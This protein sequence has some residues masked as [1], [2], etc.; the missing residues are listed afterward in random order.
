[1]QQTNMV[2]GLQRIGVFICHCG[3]NIAGTVDMERVTDEISRHPGVVHAENYIYMCSEPGQELMRKAIAEKSLN[4]IVNA[5]CSPS[6]HEKTFRRLAESQGL[7]PYCCEIA[8]IREQCSW[9]HIN[10]KEAA[11]EKAI[12]ITRAAVEK[13]R[14][15][16]TLLPIVVPLTRRALVIG[17][18][19]AGIQVALDIAGSGYPVVLVE[20][21]ESIGGHVNQLSGTFPTMEKPT[22]LLAPKIKQVITHPN[23][24]LYTSAE[25]DNVT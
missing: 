18:G 24:T 14:F 10:Y 5:N 16:M 23:I 19:I 3:S 13:L 9:P 11:T 15:N 21:E 17:A 7:N 2:K 4:G 25:V 22:V 20:K 8:N 12:A 6:L 1:M